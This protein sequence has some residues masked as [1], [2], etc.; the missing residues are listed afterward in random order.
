M[1]T[2]TNYE[3]GELLISGGSGQETRLT[4]DQANRL[5]MMARMHTIAEFIEKIPSLIA[6][7]LLAK[8][9]LSVFE[10]KNSTERWNLKE[11]FARLGT[12]TKGYT[13]KDPEAVAEVIRLN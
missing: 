6:S 12:L 7:E 5:I 13:P 9:I 8:S 1:I 4:R 11:K 2:L 3:S 10:E